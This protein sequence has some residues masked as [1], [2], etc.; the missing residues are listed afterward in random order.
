MARF[1]PESGLLI[2]HMPRTGGTWVERAVRRCG[3]RHSNWISSQPRWLPKKHSLITH[4][5]FPKM[6]R[7]RLIACFVR[8]P[9]AYYE[10]VWKWMAR[11][12]KR[13]GAVHLRRYS[14]HPRFCS[15][16][17]YQLDFNDWYRRPSRGSTSRAT[18]DQKI[19]EY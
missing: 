10:S 11:G 17:W 8:H 14:W 5:R 6:A 16:R 15:V 7:V 4:Y 18:E 9:L 19:Q 1:L 3:I 2:Q 13:R 12:M